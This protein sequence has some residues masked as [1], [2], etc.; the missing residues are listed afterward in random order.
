MFL[1]FVPWNKV[2]ILIPL[3]IHDVLLVR[4][5]ESGDPE[6]QSLRPSKTWLKLKT[7]S[8]ILLYGVNAG[9]QLGLMYFHENRQRNQDQFL[10]SME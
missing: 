6:N 7:D 4:C 8:F 2:K 1:H 9:K 10:E 5:P 3:M